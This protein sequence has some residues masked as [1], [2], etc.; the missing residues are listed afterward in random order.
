MTRALSLAAEGIRR[1]FGRSGFMLEVDRLDVPAGRVLALLGPSGSGKTTLLQILGLL[2]APDAGHVLLDGRAVTKRDREAVLSMAAVMQRPYLFRDSVGRNVAYGLKMRGVPYQERVERVGT[3][4]ARVGLSGFEKRSAMALSGGEA[5]RVSLARALAVEPRVLLLDEPL[6][7]LDP[8]LKRQLATEFARILRDTDVTAVWVTHDQDEALMV[9]DEI[10]IMRGGRVVSHGA[11][12]EVTSLPSGPWTAAFLGM[13]EPQ[14]GVV[15]KVEEGLAEVV[16]G[17]TTVAMTADGLAPGDAVLFGVRPEDVL[18]FE[19]GAELP[20][21]TA[22][23]RLPAVVASCERRGATGYVVLD[24][25]G[26]RLAATVSRAAIAE[27]GIAPGVPVLAVFKATAVRWRTDE[28]S[29][30]AT[31]EPRST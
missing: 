3:A 4:L 14:R 10:A 30:G 21:T 7:S 24:T 16:S 18:L 20:P 25:D 15:S 22:R 2:H 11:A 19:A 6:A 23:N 9:A 17:E 28:T 13:E 31:M 29:S 27:L 5:Q 26:P 1:R 8:L 12:S